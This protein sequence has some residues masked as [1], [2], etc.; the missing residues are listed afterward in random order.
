MNWQPMETAPK[1]RDILLLYQSG[2]ERR[3]TV[4]KWNTDAKG[5]NPRPYWRTHIGY[6]WGV[7]SDRYRKLLAW[8]DVDTDYQPEGK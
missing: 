7:P 2:D 8:C 4:G 6:L 5:A 1:D 3:F